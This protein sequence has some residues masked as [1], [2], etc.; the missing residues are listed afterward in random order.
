MRDVMIMVHVRL[1]ACSLARCPLHPA[2][3]MPACCPPTFTTPP[4]AQQRAYTWDA[5]CHGVSL[6]VGHCGYALP[7]SLLLIHVPKPQSL[8]HIPNQHGCISPSL[9]C[10]VWPFVACGFCCRPA[11]NVSTHHRA[12]SELKLLG[13]CSFP[14]MVPTWATDPTNAHEAAP[15]D[16]ADH[17]AY[18]LGLLRDNGFSLDGAVLPHQADEL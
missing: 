4:V 12:Y 1:L 17:I 10:V 2:D 7:P 18:Y 8:T 6:R 15:P 14:D 3:A 9:A 11:R 13:G 5:L 16:C